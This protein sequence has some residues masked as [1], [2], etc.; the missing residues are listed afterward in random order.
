MLIAEGHM[1]YA[2][3]LNGREVLLFCQGKK[4]YSRFGNKF[5]YMAWQLRYLFLDEPSKVYKIDT[6]FFDTDILCNPVGHVDKDGNVA[7][8]FVATKVLRNEFFR[9]NMYKMVGKSLDTLGKPE[10]VDCLN[11]IM[12]NGFADTHKVVTCLTDQLC[13]MDPVNQKIKR[14]RIGMGAIMRVAPHHV[15]NDI[16]MLTVH[17]TKQAHTY[18]ISVE[19]PTILGEIKVKGQSV[20]KCSAIG[21][22]LIHATKGSDFERSIHM[23]SFSIDHM[24]KPIE[25]KDR[26]WFSFA[27]PPPQDNREAHTFDDEPSPS[28]YK[29]LYEMIMRLKPEDGPT[30]AVKTLQGLASS[31]NKAHKCSASKRK[32][33]VIYINEAIKEGVEFPG[34]YNG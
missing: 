12:F 18:A 2:F 20:Y 6:G 21:S 25:M 34:G 15:A 7:V 14:S 11:H 19:S 16:V 10:K 30:D 22:Y 4:A 13:I 8:T 29:E 32:R 24:D 26:E 33:L 31:S 3:V 5:E 28:K 1:P 9:Y 17:D 23:D 27:E